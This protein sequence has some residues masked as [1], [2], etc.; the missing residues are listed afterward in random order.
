MLPRRHFIVVLILM[1]LP[2]MVQAQFTFM[3]NGN[4]ITIT[5]YAGPGGAVVIP[6]GTNDGY[7]INGI[8]EGAFAYNTNLT[9]ITIPSSITNVGAFAFAYCTNLTSAYFQGNAPPDVGN[10]LY[11]DPDAIV[12]YIPGTSGWST[13]FGGAP[14][15]GETPASEFE[16]TVNGDSITI[17]GYNGRSGLVMIP[18]LIDGYPVTTI[19]TEAFSGNGVTSVTIPDGVN[20]I[21]E[22]A[23]EY[24]ENLTNIV[25]PS[26][27]TNI[28][29]FAFEGC[30]SLRSVTIPGSVTSIGQDA[31]VDCRSLT[32]VTIANGVTSIVD[33][34]FSECGSLTSISIPGS[35]TSTGEYAFQNCESLASI[36]IPDNATS[37][38]IGA[39]YGC[40]S[41]TNILIPSG[42][43]SIGGYAFKDCESLTSIT[44]PNSVSSIGDYAFESCTN[45]TT[46]YF[47]GNAPPDD[48]TVFNGNPTTVY[49]LPGTTGWGATFGGVPTELW[50]QSQPAV[51]SFGPSFGVQSGQF[52]FLVSWA[53]NVPVVVQACTNLVNPIWIPVATNALSNG[54]NYFSDAQ[55]TNYPN[56]Y[57]RVSGP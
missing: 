33:D 54:T 10:A 28:G 51:L 27:V 3:T 32:S 45:L 55:W 9:S 25:I 13:T 23:F 39:F 17:R 29:F 24:S 37:I 4:S 52:G 8:G 20:D 1:V 26:S 42:V 56:R 36:T 2:A 43:T 53:T 48:G 16:Y 41:L 14:A 22:R 35:V 15:V 18:S 47:A 46:A 5:G 6:G 40:T 49:Y 44:L 7:R 57:Y 11:N 38:G 34:M 21:M 31:F 12:Y 50:F 19:W 30:E